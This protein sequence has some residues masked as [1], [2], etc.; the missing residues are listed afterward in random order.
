MDKDKDDDVGGDFAAFLE[1]FAYGS[2]NEQASKTLRD[3]IAAC[4]KNGGKG[5]V[6]LK[7][8]VACKGDLAA[9]AIKVTSTQPMPEMPEMPGM[10]LFATEDGSLAK[11]DP[12]QLKLP[13]KV[14]DAPSNVRTI[15]EA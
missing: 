8:S 13:A 12:R 2:I 5:S 7:L 4:R 14:L 10:T 15:R 9:L 6:T 11:S 1:G 3:V